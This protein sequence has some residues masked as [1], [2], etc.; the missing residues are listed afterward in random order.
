[1]RPVV[2]LTM[3]TGITLLGLGLGFLGLR[4]RRR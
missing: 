1:M 2:V 3:G 4:L